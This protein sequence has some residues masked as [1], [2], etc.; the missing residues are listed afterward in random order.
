MEKDQYRSTKVKKVYTLREKDRVL[1]YLGSIYRNA[2]L[3]M[4]LAE[5]E[6]A[7]SPLKNCIQDDRDF[8]YRIDRGLLCCRPQTQWLIRKEYLEN[9]DAGWYLNFVSKHTFRRLKEKAVTEFF[10]I[11]D[12]EGN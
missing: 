4:D 6:Q 10:G 5:N 12:L 8:I 7:N 3:R 1:K 2:A 11:L 9:N